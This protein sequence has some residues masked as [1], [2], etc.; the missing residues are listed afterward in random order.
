MR[1]ILNCMSALCNFPPETTK[2][3]LSS[4]LLDSTQQ[5]YGATATQTE[6]V[7]VHTPQVEHFPYSSRMRPSSLPFAE[8]AASSVIR[9]VGDPEA[10]IANN[11]VKSSGLNCSQKRTIE[12]ND[13]EILHKSLSPPL[14]PS[15]HSAMNRN[16]INSQNLQLETANTSTNG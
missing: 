8:V 3:L 11:F 16:E 14:S 9:A 10:T 4:T 6:I 5:F 1:D 7:A 12:E 15:T 13:Y 2:R